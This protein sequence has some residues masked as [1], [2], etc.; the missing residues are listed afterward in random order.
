MT[1]ETSKK[2][3][4]WQKIGLSLICITAITG[5]MYPVF[6]QNDQST[7]PQPEQD[8]RKPLERLDEQDTDRSP[9]DRVSQDEDRSSLFDRVF[10][11]DGTESVFQ[12]VFGNQNIRETLDRTPI[13][14]VLAQADDREQNQN[15]VHKPDNDGPSLID[16]NRPVTPEESVTPIPP[17][18]E[19]INPPE[20]VPPVNPEEPISPEP[21]INP[22]VDPPI[23]PPVD[24]P[25]IAVN[26][27]RLDQLVGQAQTI[28][29]NQYLSDGVST[30]VY[31]RRV[32]ERMLEDRNSTQAQVDLQ[33]SRLQQA[34]DQL[35]LKGDSTTLKATIQQADTIDRERFTQESLARLDE[36]VL[37]ANQMLQTDE[38]T[39]EALDRMNRRLVR[40]IDQLEERSSLELAL[41]DLQRLIDQAEMFEADHYTVDSFALLTAAIEDAKTLVNEGTA[42]EEEIR[43]MHERLEQAIDQLIDVAN[44]DQLVSLIAHARS[45]DSE[46]YT[47]DSWNVLIEALNRAEELLQAHELSQ[48]DVDQVAENLRLAI[49]QLVLEETEEPAPDL[50]IDSEDPLLLPDL[51]AIEIESDGEIDQV[52]IVEWSNEP[53]SSPSTNELDLPKSTDT[54]E[55]EVPELIDVHLEA[56]ST[57]EPLELDSE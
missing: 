31:E 28:N 21:P 10:G 19:D 14:D 23:N 25:E 36:R 33:I 41:L 40:A 17:L 29:T 15:V 9:L 4:K 1:K 42:S 13:L 52:T 30:F 11:N 43:T 6:S 20:P 46:S 24:P 5:F 8:T 2:M 56:F 18:P 48:N 51:P 50:D 37:E 35:V 7:Q 26:Y 54:E 38:H 49:D 57:E 32:S 44:T 12:Q 53:W 3:T 39:Q 55:S 34:I 22:P 27:E 47:H 16:T 45:L